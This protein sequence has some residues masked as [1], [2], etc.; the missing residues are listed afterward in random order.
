MEKFELKKRLDDILC[1]IEN[2]DM[3]FDVGYGIEKKKE[4][5]LL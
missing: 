5:T 1:K 4:N 2:I 3:M